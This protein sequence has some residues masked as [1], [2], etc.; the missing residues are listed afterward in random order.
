MASIQFKSYEDAQVFIE[1]QVDKPI[2]KQNTKVSDRIQ[3]HAHTTYLEDGAFTNSYDISYPASSVIQSIVINT[4]PTALIETV[5]PADMAAISGGFMLLTDDGTEV[6][7]AS[8][9]LAISNGKLVGLPVIDREAIILRKGK[10]E[11]RQV[12]ALG[13]ITMGSA[14]ISWAGSA[15]RHN[16]EAKIFASGNLK[17]GHKSDPATQGR[18]YVMQQSRYTSKYN[19]RDLVDVGYNSDSKGV[20]IATSMS[21]TGGLDICAQDFIVRMQRNKLKFADVATIDTIDDLRISEIDGGFSAGPML[22]ETDFA[23]HSINYD[24]SLG[25]KPPFIERRMARAVVYATESNVIH[26]RLF[27]GRPGSKL[28]EGV[29]PSEAVKMILLEQPV[30]SGIFLDPG[31]SAK[32]FARINGVGISYGNRHYLKWPRQPN[33]SF[34]WTPDHGRPITSIIKLQ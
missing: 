19:D 9:N 5:Q 3:F 13:L 31:Q 15:T 4:S 33:D 18:R 23:S 28:F 6:N 24:K 21:D 34:L 22:N 29:T 8:L 16:A 27:D 11:F 17:I 2:N 30:K 26:L 20:F 14:Q 12:R 25:N 32:I 7:Q 1:R 10:L